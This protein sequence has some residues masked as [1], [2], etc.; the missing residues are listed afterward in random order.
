MAS[1]NPKAQVLA[2][3]LTFIML[4][5]LA[6]LVGRGG[7]TAGAVGDVQGTNKPLGVAILAVT[8]VGVIALYL[9][10]QRSRD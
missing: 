3:S 4:A 1:S 5:G 9:K 6:F 10:Y 2:K 8:V 7:F